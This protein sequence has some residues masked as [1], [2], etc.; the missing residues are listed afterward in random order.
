VVFIGDREKREKK[1]NIFLGGGGGDPIEKIQLGGRIPRIIL[2]CRVLKKPGCVGEEDKLAV[3]VRL[4]SS[5]HRAFCSL[6]N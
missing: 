2:K 6:F 4:S 1:K 5:L 3:Y